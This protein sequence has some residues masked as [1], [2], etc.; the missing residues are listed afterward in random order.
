MGVGEARG[1]SA[2]LGVPEDNRGHR[3]QEA[4]SPERMAVRRLHESIFPDARACGDRAPREGA[5]VGTGVSVTAP[6]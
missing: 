3:L 4:A 2:A 1:K 5:Q 6:K